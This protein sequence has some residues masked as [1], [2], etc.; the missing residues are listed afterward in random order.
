M[1]LKVNFLLSCNHL[2]FQTT[3][4]HIGLTML[5][6]VSASGSTSKIQIIPKKKKKC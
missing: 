2:T 4:L 1:E 6:T 3:T 5:K